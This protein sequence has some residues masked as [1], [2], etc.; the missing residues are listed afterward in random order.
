MF[1]HIQ[2]CSGKAMYQHWRKTYL[3]HNQSCKH[4]NK[5]VKIMF[6]IFLHSYCIVLFYIDTNNYGRT[7]SEYIPDHV[8]ALMYVKTFFSVTPPQD[9]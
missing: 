5:H 1:E 9:G 4:D 6:K 3:L 2:L 8:Q 7:C